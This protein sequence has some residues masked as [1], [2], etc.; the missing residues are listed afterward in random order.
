MRQRVTIAMAMACTPSLLLAGKPTTGLDATAR[1]QI[2]DLMV[3]LKD[4]DGA[5][6]LL[7]THDMGVIAEMAQKK[8][9]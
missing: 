2:L 1:A 3:Q 4:S 6:I 5:A 8:P 9:R 7:I